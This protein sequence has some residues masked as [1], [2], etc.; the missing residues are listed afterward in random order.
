MGFESIAS[1]R[2][3]IERLASRELPSVTVGLMEQLQSLDAAINE[4]AQTVDHYFEDH[5][6]VDQVMQYL[7]E[8]QTACRKILALYDSAMSATTTSL[9]LLAS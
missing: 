4:A 1:V 7:Y 9:Q 5:D 8:A 3:G 6:G 2:E